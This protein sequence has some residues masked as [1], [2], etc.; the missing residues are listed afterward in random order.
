[1]KWRFSI[2]DTGNAFITFRALCSRSDRYSTGTNP[3]TADWASDLHKYM[4]R[5]VYLVS[6]DYL[7][8]RHGTIDQW[9]FLLPQPPKS[10]CYCLLRPRLPLR[11]RLKVAL[12][13]RM[14][15]FT[16]GCNLSQISCDILRFVC[17]SCHKFSPFEKL[18]SLPSSLWSSML[19]TSQPGHD[20]PA[21]HFQVFLWFRTSFFH[22]RT[23]NGFRVPQVLAGTRRMFLR[24]L[25]VFFLCF[26]LFLSFLVFA[27]F[28][29]N[30]IGYN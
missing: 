2:I 24:A 18:P 16:W 7:N 28:G 5:R 10:G 30:P 13:G 12:R 11:W 27:F 22:F 20:Q 21:L 25:L 23:A 29:G 3:S 14:G 4:G 19:L 15:S 9:V 8:G 1:M 17:D 6:I 26:V